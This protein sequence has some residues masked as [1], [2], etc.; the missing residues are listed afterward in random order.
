MSEPPPRRLGARALF[1]AVLDEGTF[2][3]WDNAPLPVAADGS[4]Y[5]AELAEA[6]AKAGTDESV[7][8][9]EGRIGGRRVAL[10][11]GEFRFLAGSIGR[12]SAERVVLAFERARPARAFPFAAPS[13]G[14]TRMQEGTPAFV[15]MVKI[16][17]AVAA[18]KAAKLPYITYL[19]HPTTGGVFASWGSPG[20]CDGGRAGATIGF[21]GARVY[22]ALYG[23][24]FPR[25]SRPPRTSTSTACSMPSCRSKGWQRS[26]A[27]SSTWCSH[28]VRPRSSPTCPSSHRGGRR[29][30]V[31]RCLASPRPARGARAAP[32][33]RPRRAAPLRHGRGRMGPVTLPR[34]RP[35][36][37][38]P[39]RGPRPG[40][41][42]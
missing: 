38:G 21:L 34:P 24:P 25:A 10:I 6:A 37:R 16:S 35:V 14:G 33:W 3:S 5:A 29:V 36:R 18:F 17:A 9:G 23:Q 40:P 1:E 7:I 26:R 8:T 42:P 20:P 12:T 27:A 19:R 32:V 15:T 41:T 13:S 2:R 31:D 30:D 4:A 39:V 11:A 22:E 28:P